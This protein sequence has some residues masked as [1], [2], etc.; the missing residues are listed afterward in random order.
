MIGQVD[1]RMAFPEMRASGR[2][3]L[4]SQVRDAAVEST[5]GGNQRVIPQERREGE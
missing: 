3:R 5:G 4:I 1:R 2:V